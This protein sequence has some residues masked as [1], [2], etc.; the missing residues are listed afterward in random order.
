MV[1]SVFPY[2][3]KIPTTENQLFEYPEGQPGWYPFP[4]ATQISQSDCPAK[5]Y[6]MLLEGANPRETRGGSDKSPGIWIGD[7]YHQIMANIRRY[8]CETPSLMDEAVGVV[9]DHLTRY[10][11]EKI[12]TFPV[13]E[14][15]KNELKS[16]IE[17][18]IKNRVKSFRGIIGNHVMFEVPVINSSMRVEYGNRS[19]E[20]PIW[21]R[22]D[23]VNFTRRVI[24]ERYSQNDPPHSKGHQVWLNHRALATLSPEIVKTLPPYVQQALSNPQPFRL[25]VETPSSDHEITEDYSRETIQAYNWY[26]MAYTSTHILDLLRQKRCREPPPSGDCPFCFHHC[27]RPG[28][29]RRKHPIPTN[30]SRNEINRLKRELLYDS[31]WNDRKLYKPCILSEAKQEKT[32]V[33]I[34]ARVIGLEKHMISCEHSLVSPPKLSPRSDVRIPLYSFFFGP[35]IGGRVAKIHKNKIE[36]KTHKEPF[37]PQKGGEI[38]IYPEPNHVKR[39]VSM[40]QNLLF[41]LALKLGKGVGTQNL[42]RVREGIVGEF[43]IP[44]IDSN[45]KRHDFERLVL[46]KCEEAGLEMSKVALYLGVPTLKVRTGSR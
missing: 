32:Q 30:Q 19:V 20:Y 44:P 10:A 42:I 17:E 46:E 26:A 38:R 16:R 31:T 45:R 28:R 13:N 4:F 1:N 12:N 15:A 2:R 21:C 14:Q 41:N 29:S 23:E 40:R 39:I 22:I 33:F 8:V 27:F 36:I 9:S 5:F 25:V 18:N 3:Y 11:R 34:K 6:Y 35:Y 43:E 24:I 37:T 7:P